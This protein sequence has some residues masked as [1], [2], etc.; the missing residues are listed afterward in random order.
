MCKVL[1]LLDVAPEVNQKAGRSTTQHMKCP[2]CSALGYFIDYRN[3]NT[4]HYV[5]CPQCSGFGYVKADI[6]ITY[7]PDDSGTN[8]FE[9]KI[10]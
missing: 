10:K 2:Y 8:F 9:N 5:R 1:N 4:V 7:A 6:R 3:D